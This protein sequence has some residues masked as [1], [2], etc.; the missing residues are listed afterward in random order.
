MD[1]PCRRFHPD[2]PRRFRL[3]QP[4]FQRNGDRAD[5]PMAAHRQTS[6]GLDK[7]DGDIILRV[8]RRIKD[9]AA[10]HIMAA[11]LEHQPLADPVVFL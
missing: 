3:D 8:M 7:K 2:M 11:R 6:A 1:K 4:L 5:R 10:H 9:A